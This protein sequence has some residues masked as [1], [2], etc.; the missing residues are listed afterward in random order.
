[1]GVAR[2]RENKLEIE[3]DLAWVALL[4]HAT[5]DQFH[6][7]VGARGHGG[8]MRDHGNGQTFAMLGGDQVKNFAAGFCI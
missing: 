4:R 5:V 1:M 6:N 2:A 3:H 8:I 7:A